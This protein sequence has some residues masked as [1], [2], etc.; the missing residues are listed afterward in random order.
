ILGSLV[1][2]RQSDPDAL[3]AIFPSDHHYAQEDTFLAGVQS[4]F[5]AA[6]AN[7]G[8]VV[9]IGIEADFPEVGYGYIEPRGKLRGR[10]QSVRRFWEKPTSQLA[11]TLLDRGCLWNTFVMVG[12][13]CA[14]LDL[15]KTAAPEVYAA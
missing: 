8:A 4:A 15:I 9:L 10:L 1:Q 7:P 5:S 2:V 11:E 3:V 13:V 6:E 12:R 14:F